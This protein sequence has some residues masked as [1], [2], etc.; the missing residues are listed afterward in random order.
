MLGKLGSDLIPTQHDVFSIGSGNNRFLTGHFSDLN[1]D[2]GVDTHSLSTE[3]VYFTDPDDDDQGL[4]P[5]SPV[6][7]DE[8]RNLTYTEILSSRDTTSVVQANSADWANHA[9]TERIQV[10]TR[11]ALNLTFNSG[12]GTNDIFKEFITIATDNPV[13]DARW[14]DITY[15]H[16]MVLPYNTVVKKIILRG[17]A[18]QSATVNI[19][20]HTNNGVTD[21]NTIEYK[22]FTETPTATA[23]NT[24]QINNEPK[25]FTFA[26]TTSALEGST[27]GISISGTK[28]ISAVNLSIVLAYSD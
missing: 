3:M 26:D 16:A 5:T 25:V 20:V 17:T 11:S 14:D 9:P 13:G 21:T 19:G 2:V 15:A 23:E 24:F 4:S 7:Y 8:E 10:L 27:L 6:V 1:V 22:Y 28:V 12:N 18:T